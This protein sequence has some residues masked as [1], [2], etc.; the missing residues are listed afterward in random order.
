MFMANAASD[1][2]GIQ[3]AKAAGMR[4]VAVAQTFRAEQL[5]D[6]DLVRESIANLILSD[7]TG[8]NEL[9]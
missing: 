7:L 1:V 2:N 4:C 8:R 6:D 5:H 3:A 9:P